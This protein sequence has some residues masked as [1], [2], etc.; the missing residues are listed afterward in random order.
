M[1]QSSLTAGGA[2]R[3]YPLAVHIATLFVALLAI[4]GLAI[5]GLA[6]YRSAEMLTRATDDLFDRI[7][8]ETTL[9]VERIVTPG[10]ALVDVLAQTRLATAG[11]LA[12]RLDTL[13]LLHEGFA[14]SA[15][16]S[17]IYASYA[18]GDFFLVRR[19]PESPEART[20]PG[21]PA[22]AAFLVQS[23][24]RDR[25]GGAAGTFVWLDAALAR[26]ATREPAG[27]R[28]VRPSHPAVVSRRSE[29]G[30]PDQDPR[31]TRSSPPTRSAS[32]SRAAPPG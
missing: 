24:E 17:A 5:G 6:Y 18:N 7:A 29:C 31:P 8:R 16:V 15:N 30:R 4:A 13:P 12:E 32:P 19:V 27:L 25:Q 26:L 20:A 21:G 10:E 11:S 2:R 9:E 3:R 1:A 14:V 22:R 28:R 23:I